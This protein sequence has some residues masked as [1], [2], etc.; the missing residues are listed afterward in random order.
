M[1]STSL[2]ID[3][4]SIAR[5]SPAY[6]RVVGEEVWTHVFPMAIIVG[7]GRGRLGGTRVYWVTPRLSFPSL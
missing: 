1:G 6:L 2:E 7:G 3:V 5:Q 4:I